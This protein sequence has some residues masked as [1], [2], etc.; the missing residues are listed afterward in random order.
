MLLLFYFFISF[1]KQKQNK[2]KTFFKSFVLQIKL[3][4]YIRIEILNSDDLFISIQLN[5]K[6]KYLKLKLKLFIS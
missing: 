3:K 2:K 4:N 6:K 1:I 5:I